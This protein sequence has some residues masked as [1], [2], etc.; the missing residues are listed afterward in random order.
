MN[1]W[2]KLII[3][4]LSLVALGVAPA[5]AAPP[6][7]TVKAATPSS[8]YQGESLDV[9]VSGSGFDASAK[10]Q[11]FVSGTT[12]PGGIKFGFDG[13]PCARSAWIV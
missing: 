10:V 4:C 8:A 12:N 13:F 9:V 1:A 5:G 7:V 11:F 2:K 6:R 3:T